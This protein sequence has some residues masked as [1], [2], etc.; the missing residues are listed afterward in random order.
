MPQEHCLVLFSVDPDRGSLYKS[1][2]TL[3]MALKQIALYKLSS[4]WIAIS[5]CFRSITIKVS[6]NSCLLDTLCLCTIV[7]HHGKNFL[8]LLW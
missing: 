7:W 8:C 4:L 1:W 2:W 5:H 6:M 3:S